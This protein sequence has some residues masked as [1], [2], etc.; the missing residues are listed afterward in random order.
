MIVINNELNLLLHNKSLG[1][2]SPST[3]QESDSV[4]SGAKIKIEKKGHVTMIF[5]PMVC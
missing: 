3:L 5:F 2:G 1:P 4:L